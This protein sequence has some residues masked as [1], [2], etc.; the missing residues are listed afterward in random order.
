MHG[1][2]EHRRLTMDGFWRRAEVT[3]SD[4]QRRSG[5]ERDKTIYVRADLGQPHRL[6]RRSP[7]RNP[8]A[9]GTLK[10][11]IAK[12]GALTTKPAFMIHTGDITHLS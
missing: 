5:N 1:T 11:A 12:V 6:P 10:E 4:R 3:G 9:L 2:G 7:L 8:D